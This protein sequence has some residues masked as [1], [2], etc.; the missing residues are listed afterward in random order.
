M[1]HTSHVVS[2]LF[3]YSNLDAEVFLRVDDPSLLPP[4]RDLHSAA[5]DGEEDCPA[6][7]PA[8]LAWTPVTD[9]LIQISLRGEPWE[10]PMSETDVF[11]Q[12]ENLLTRLFCAEL[13]DRLQLHA[14]AVSH[15]DHGAILICGPSRAGKT[16]LTLSL[17]L[18]GW[19]WLSDE[20]ILID[21]SAP[22]RLL[23]F[24]RNF[25][26]KE[27]SWDLFPETG[28]LPHRRE[29]WS[30]YHQANVRFIDPEALRPG[31]FAAS[32]SL[33]AI[34]LPEF[35][36]DAR[37]PRLERIGGI[38]AAQTLLPEIRATSPASIAIVAQWAREFPI[39][40]FTHSDPRDIRDAIAG[41][42]WENKVG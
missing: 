39:H 22:L 31:A 40:R 35:R 24:R 16:S 21:E 4:A 3:R 26:L 42:E 2:R 17:M 7:R 30:G 29:S 18:A 37:E 28:D 11:F 36:A 20:L 27:S 8:D 9:G 6:D 12:S 19:N 13:D 38:S 14:A 23:G 33:S 15:P 10:A 5:L 25:N 34:L 1:A 41:I 32:A